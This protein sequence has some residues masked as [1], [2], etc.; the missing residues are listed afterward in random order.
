MRKKLAFTMIELLVVAITIFACVKLAVN[1]TDN[2]SKKDKTVNILKDLQ[3][4]ISKS[5][6][7]NESTDNGVASW[8]WRGDSYNVAYG[9]LTKYLLVDYPDAVNCSNPLNCVGGYSS[10]DGE[11]YTNFRQEDEYARFLINKEKI[12]IALKTVDPCEKNQ[13]TLCAIVAVDIN[14]K[15]LPNKL[16]YDVFLFGVY[17]LG[18][19]MPYG[20]NLDK[21]EVEKN[22][23]P[24]SN[25]ETCAA[26]IMRDGWQMRTIKPNVYP[27][28][29]IKK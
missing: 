2:F 15:D 27:M 6:L 3:A 9:I 24:D 25:G 17:S 7:F 19:F 28:Y 8:L 26:K 29:E 1:I 18:G 12:H 14:N 4:T 16:G 13:N 10:M 11:D 20:Y 23:S 5:I 21:D 22:C